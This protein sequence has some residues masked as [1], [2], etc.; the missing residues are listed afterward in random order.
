MVDKTIVIYNYIMGVIMV[1][2]PTY[3]WGSPSCKERHKISSMSRSSVE[4]FA[5]NVTSAWI[6]REPGIETPEL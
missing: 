5:F 4:K 2:K 3:N 6:E 1:Y